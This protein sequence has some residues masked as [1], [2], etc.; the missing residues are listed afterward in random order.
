[1][2]TSPTSTGPTAGRSKTSVPTH[3]S[4]HIDGVAMVN[5]E[6]PVNRQAIDPKTAI[7]ISTPTSVMR[8][9]RGGCP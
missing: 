3:R 5:K 6:P 7:A 1:M 2:T 4:G 8:I 9:D